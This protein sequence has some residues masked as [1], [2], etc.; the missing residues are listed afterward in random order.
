MRVV[1]RNMAWLLLSQITTWSASIVML[2]VA[3]RRL[4]DTNYGTVEFAIVFVAFFGLVAGLGTDTYLVK[5]TARDES[6]VGRYVFNALVMKLLLTAVLST[7]AVSLGYFL[8]Y[9]GDLLK[10]VAIFCVLMTVSVLSNTFV[11]GLQGLQRMGR[12]AA[13][14]AAQEVVS[15]G[16]ALLVLVRH[17]SLV[18]YGIA[19]STG[20]LVPLVSNALKF[21]PHLRAGMHIDFDL[22]KRIVLGGL[23]F[24]TWG[25]I[26]MIYGSIDLP[27]LESLAGSQ[28]VGWYTLA[29]RWVGLPAFFA[30]IVGTAILPSLSARFESATFKFSSQANTAIRLVFFVGAPIATGIILIAKDVLR[31]LY[32]NSGFSHAV[33]VMQILSLHLP[34]V[35]V[36]M[37]LG[38]ALI[39]SDRQNKWMLVGCTAAALNIGI[40]FI[41]I[42]WSMRLFDNGAI[43]A[44]VVTV[45]TECLMLGGAIYL[46][47]AGVLDLATA[48]SLLRIA[49]ASLAMVP[50]VLALHSAGLPAKVAVGAL[51]FAAASLVL[52][53]V[54]LDELRGGFAGSFRSRGRTVEQTDSEQN[55]SEQIEPITESSGDLR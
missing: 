19:L 25:A 8:G 39:A 43:G 11:A 40:N 7:M 42:P 28:Q 14:A 2:I 33:P 47:P 13:A 38:T 37:M 24:L 21:W 26:L 15:N 41:A 50:P 46:R 44:S 32:P 5:V 27:I 49:I 4:G 45:L 17:G 30:A 6:Q 51:T 53:V 23:P 12:S 52:R 1:V 31:I 16:L 29:Y 35:T 10:L 48:K 34:L 20:S 9:R 18:L 36:T 55:D 22:W 54:T 3:P